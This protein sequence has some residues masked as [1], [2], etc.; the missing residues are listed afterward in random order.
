[1]HAMFEAAAGMPALLGAVAAVVAAAAVRMFGTAAAAVQLLGSAA[2][3]MSGKCFER[4]Q[5]RMRRELHD[6]VVLDRLLLLRTNRRESATR[7]TST[8]TKVVSLKNV[9]NNERARL[10]QELTFVVERR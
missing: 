3:R 5:S 9:V 6:Q 4:M 8:T 1:M 10:L 7:S 2:V